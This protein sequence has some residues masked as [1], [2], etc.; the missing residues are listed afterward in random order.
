MAERYKQKYLA[1]KAEISTIVD[2]VKNRGGWSIW[3]TVFKGYDEVRASLLDFEGTAKM[4]FDPA[5]HYEPIDR[6][7]GLGDPT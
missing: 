3:F 4:C 5:N 7:P 1:G 6:N 2:L